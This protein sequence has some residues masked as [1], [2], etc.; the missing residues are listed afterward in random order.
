MQGRLGAIEDI[1][2]LVELLVLPEGGWITGQTLF[3]N[4]GYV[5][6]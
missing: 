3:V 1:V 4:G 2:P 6:R 5:A